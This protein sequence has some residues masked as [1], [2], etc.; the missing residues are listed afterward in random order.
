MLGALTAVFTLKLVPGT[1]ELDCGNG[2]LPCIDEAL[3]G[4]R[5][6]PSGKERFRG[7]RGYLEGFKGSSIVAKP[8]AAEAHDPGG[9][10]GV[11][12]ITLEDPPGL[13]P[14]K[15]QVSGVVLL[16]SGLKAAG[17][18]GTASC[19]QQAGEGKQ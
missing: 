10:V 12:I 4:H 11:C 5:T 3:A 14:R 2:R 13:E 19:K 18:L 1:F 6:S 7:A 15:A 9:L 8:L 17:P 16:D